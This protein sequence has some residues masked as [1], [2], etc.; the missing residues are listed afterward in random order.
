MLRRKTVRGRLEDLIVYSLTNCGY[1]VGWPGFKWTW[2]TIASW[3]DY[4]DE[5]VEFEHIISTPKLTSKDIFIH[6]L[7]V[8]RH[9]FSRQAL[10]YALKVKQALVE[11]HKRA[12][13]SI[14]EILRG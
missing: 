2:P 7:G 5:E 13:R 6:Q 12:E 14:D 11:K 4:V 10:E 3:R 1:L 8:G 9:T